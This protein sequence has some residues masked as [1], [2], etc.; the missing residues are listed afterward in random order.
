MEEEPIVMCPRDDG[1][2][3]KCPRDGSVPGSL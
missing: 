2:E 3:G 1:G